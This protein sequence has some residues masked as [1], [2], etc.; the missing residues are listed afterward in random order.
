VVKILVF[1]IIGIVAGMFSGEKLLE[2]QTADVLGSQTF[3][4][5]S[6]SE[7]TDPPQ[8][9]PAPNLDLPTPT[10]DP[11]L[12]IT[13][14]PTSTPTTIPSPTITTSPTPKPTSTPAPLPTSTPSPTTTPAPTS[15]PTPTSTPNPTPSPVPISPTL[16]PTPTLVSIVQAPADLEPVFKEFADK[17]HVD[18]NLLKKIADCE[19]HFNSGVV[20]PNGLYAGMFQFAV[21]TWTTNRNLIPADPNPDLRFGARESIETA[22]F[23][24]SRG[25]SDSWPSCSH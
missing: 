4:S 13:S 15:P 3:P 10:P 6:L 14:E 1:I 21:G 7:L 23:M 8:I 12:I 20:S 24:I 22:A 17:Y 5:D 2:H 16:T 25:Q 18:A 19:S 11:I 9:S